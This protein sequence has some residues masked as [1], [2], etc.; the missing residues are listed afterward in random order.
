MSGPVLSSYNGTSPGPQ[1]AHT[2]TQ[3]IEG[4]G[5]GGQGGEAEGPSTLGH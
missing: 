3:D 1:R 4:G 2:Q 5:V